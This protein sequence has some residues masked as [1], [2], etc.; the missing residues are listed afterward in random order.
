MEILTKK[1]QGQNTH[2]DLEQT[3]KLNKIMFD[4][5]MYLQRGFSGQDL[6]RALI[7]YGIL[8]QKEKEM[9]RMK[10]ERQKYIFEQLSKLKQ[11]GEAKE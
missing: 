5:Y 9:Q 4:D 2:I 3:E 1:I 11:D 8:E 6:E 10:E 7:K